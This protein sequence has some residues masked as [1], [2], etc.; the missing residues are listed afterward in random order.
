MQEI[1][2]RGRRERTV[3]DRLQ[4]RNGSVALLVRVNE[5][6]SLATAVP[7]T[8]CD[9]N[10]CRRPGRHGPSTFL[11]PA[12]IYCPC[13]ESVHVNVLGPTESW[14]ETQDQV[15]R[16]IHPAAHGRRTPYINGALAVLQASS[17]AQC[18]RPQPGCPCIVRQV[19]NVGSWVMQE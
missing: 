16:Q 2:A 5:T 10:E 9:R 14:I 4:G 8:R 6:K 11:Q 7:R 19:E 12:G 13:V 15:Y 3:D 1:A 18:S 17:A